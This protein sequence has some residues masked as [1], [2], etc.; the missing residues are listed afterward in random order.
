MGTNHLSCINSTDSTY[1]YLNISNF[2][3]ATVSNQIVISIFVG[4]PLGTGDYT[5]QTITSN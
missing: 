3:S 2:L 4:S 5:V 1:T